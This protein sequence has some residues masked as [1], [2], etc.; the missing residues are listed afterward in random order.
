MHILYYQE[1]GSDVMLEL[2][3]DNCTTLI[4]TVNRYQYYLNVI[5]QEDRALLDWIFYA[6]IHDNL[7]D[8]LWQ[9]AK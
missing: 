5:E 6:Y 8:D 7:E 4:E 9:A 2:S 3:F 1:K